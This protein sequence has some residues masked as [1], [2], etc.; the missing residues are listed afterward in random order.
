MIGMLCCSHSAI[1]VPFL[2]F[3]PSATRIFVPSST[4][5][6]CRGSI[7]FVLSSFLYSSILR[8]SSRTMFKE[9]FLLRAIQW[10]SS[11]FTYAKIGVDHKT[12]VLHNNLWAYGWQTR[13]HPSGMYA[14]LT[15]FQVHRSTEQR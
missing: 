5:N 4:V 14:S 12:F 1:F 8:P 15:E 11:F 9:P 3:E 2:T 10:P 13:Y 7:D 6:V